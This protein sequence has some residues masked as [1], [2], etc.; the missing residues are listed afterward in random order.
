MREW[1]GVVRGGRGIKW[2]CSSANELPRPQATQQQRHTNKRHPIDPNDPIQRHSDSMLTA[3]L[4]QPTPRDELGPSRRWWI[5]V[6][7]VVEESCFGSEAL[8]R[9]QDKETINEIKPGSD[10]SCCCVPNPVYPS[11]TTYRGKIG[12]QAD[13]L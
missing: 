9:V 6:E 11:I 12:S 5:A 10:P 4:F 8:G 1:V 2:A 13:E 7:E 3:Y